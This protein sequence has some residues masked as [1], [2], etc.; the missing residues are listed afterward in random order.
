MIIALILAFLIGVFSVLLLEAF[1]LYKWWTSREADARNVYPHRTKVSNPECLADY[2]RTEGATKEEKCMSLN[3]FLSFLWREWRDSPQ[4]K[5]FFLTKMNAEFSDLMRGKAASKLIEQI[6]I[7]ELSLG[8]SLPV[9]KGATV[10]KIGTKDPNEVPKELDIALDL[11]YSGGCHM[12]IQVDLV[13]NK[14]VYLA[15]KLA[16]LRGRARLELSRHPLTHW[17]LAFYEEP[18]VEFEA[19]SQFEGKN[20]PQLTS[21]ILNHLRKSIQKKHTLPAYKIRYSPLFPELKPQDEAQEVYVHDSLVTVGDLEVTVVGCSRLPELEN[22]AWQYC[23]LSVDMLPWSQLAENRRAMWPTFEIEISRESNE[24]SFGLTLSK[25]ISEDDLG[26]AII[27]NTIVVGSPAYYAGVIAK[28][29]LIA[30]DGHKIESLKQAAKMI[31]NKSRFTATV[32]RP[33]TRITE[34][35]SQENSSENE[36]NSKTVVDFKNVSLNNDSESEDEF[37]NIVV[38]LFEHGDSEIKEVLSRST[39]VRQRAEKKLKAK[40]GRKASSGTSTTEHG[41]QVKPGVELQVTRDQKLPKVQTKEIKQESPA[42]ETKNSDQNNPATAE[43]NNQDATASSLTA[44]DGLDY[45]RS[46][47]VSSSTDPVWNETFK[48]QV[49]KKDQY[50][51]VCVW[52]KSQ[53]K[54]EKDTV[55]GYVTVPL[56][57]IALRCLSF[58]SKRHE[59]CYVLVSP[60]SDRVIS[61]QPYLRSLPGLKK[62]L[63]CGDMT[64]I[65]LHTPSLQDCDETVLDNLDSLNDSEPKD[66]SQEKDTLES[67]EP[68]KHQFNFTQF[69]FPTRCSYC[70]KKVWTKVAFQCRTCAM[71]C[72]KKCLQNCMKYT[73]CM[74]SR[75][76]TAGWFSKTTSQPENAGKQKKEEDSTEGDETV[77]EAGSSESQRDQLDGKREK[78]SDEDEMKQTGKE[79]TKMETNGKSEASDE[80]T[81]MTNDQLLQKKDKPVEPS[82]M[83]RAS[84]R[85]REAGRE[86]FSNLP[87]ETRKN[88]IQD[89]MKRLQVE[90]DEENET[91][92]ELYERR[93]QAKEA[94]KKAVIESLLAK[95]EERS[96][97]LAMLMLQ[98]C[99]GYQS[100]V[101]AEEQD[102]YQL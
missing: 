55:L 13:F 72:H 94:R 52:S 15:V 59:E 50:L 31:K 80:E 47:L 40:Q 3:L 86:L 41:S 34:K 67:L 30:I 2:F 46:K 68:P 102:M 95:S 84:E 73:Y 36:Q 39:E 81:T 54:N 6:T 63:C 60:H 92:T 62:N 101:E 19:E 20:L 38:P 29:I 37:V 82:D 53:E 16:S 25:E 43:G 58:N 89:M 93:S 48:F 33:P 85:V 26:K 78:T 21:L 11:E 100:C 75:K 24:I 65:F 97:S 32:Q 5:S 61:N 44:L 64:L 18:E 98:F 4:M 76:S 69:Y 22:G 42:S 87:V 66:K 27:I 1:L 23:T 77:S 70:N 9:I 90:I 88:K 28:D 17:S 7:E 14:S 71:I 45:T 8:T 56:M 49:L 99:S 10:M 35:G 96:Q 83:V 79:E 12:A 57:D 74:S 51:N 91:R